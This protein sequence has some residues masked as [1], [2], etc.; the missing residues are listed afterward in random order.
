MTKKHLQILK[1]KDENLTIFISYFLSF[2]ITMSL[3]QGWLVGAISGLLF[4]SVMTWLHYYFRKKGKNISRENP[5]IINVRL[6]S[7]VSYLNLGGAVMFTTFCGLSWFTGQMG[8][9]ILMLMFAILCLASIPTLCSMVAIGRTSIIK[10]TNFFTLKDQVYHF[11]DIVDVR[12]TF[13]QALKVYFKNGSQLSLP[14]LSQSFLHLP[15]HHYEKP[16]K[17]QTEGLFRLRAEILRRKEQCATH[18]DFNEIQMLKRQPYT[19]FSMWKLAS[20]VIIAFLLIGFGGLQLQK[21]SLASISQDPPGEVTLSD[22]K[23]AFFLY[24]GEKFYA[25]IKQYEKA[26]HQNKD[27]NCRFA[28]YLYDINDDKEKAELLMKISCNKSDPHSCYNV[29]INANSSTSEIA[30]AADILE[31]TCA[32]EMN[33]KLTCCR[34]YGQAKEKRLPASTNKE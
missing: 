19:G 28:S 21:E 18:T 2:G 3:R 15:E 6:P 29:Y 20:F 24:K 5:D 9:S 10:K 16:V 23:N 27:Y 1:S 32:Q 26:C 12:V 17:P 11:R 13:M 22:F 31:E 34:C 33:S 7:I 4:A 14:A 25:L 8:A 30:N